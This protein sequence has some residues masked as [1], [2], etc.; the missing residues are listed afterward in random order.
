MSRRAPVGS[1]HSYFLCFSLNDQCA[2][3]LAPFLFFIWCKRVNLGGWYMSRASEHL[4]LHL[5]WGGVFR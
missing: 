3:G 5:D 2:R 1:D 4:L